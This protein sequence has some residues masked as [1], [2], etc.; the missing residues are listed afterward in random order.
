MAGTEATIRTS[1]QIVAGE[2]EYANRPTMFQALVTGRKGPSPGAIG[3]SVAGTN[4]DFGEL[5]TPGLCRIQNIDP[6]NYVTIGIWDP[7]F[8]KFYPLLELL[9]GESYIYRLSRDLAWEYG[10]AT[11]TASG[12]ETNTLQIRADTAP[13]NVLVEAFEV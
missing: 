4:V 7:E 3:C 1:L 10:T 6:T 8:S 5:T 12:P 2:I 9:A 11:G 13:C